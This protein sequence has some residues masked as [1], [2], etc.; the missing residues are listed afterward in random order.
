MIV[1]VQF[2]QIEISGGK[3]RI[4]KK[5]FSQQQQTYTLI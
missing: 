2:C 4:E 3:R 5:K 1:K